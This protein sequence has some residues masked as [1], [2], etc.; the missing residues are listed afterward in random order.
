G[1][2]WGASTINCNLKRRSGILYNEAY[3]ALLVLNRVQMVKDPET[4]K[5]ISR[6]N[7]PEQWHVVEA[8]HLRIVSDELWNAVQTRKKLYGATRLHK[9]RRPKHMFSGLV[10]CVCCGATYTIKSQDQL[11][12]TAH[13]ER[14]TC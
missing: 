2:E 7:P 14:G 4:G 5:R 9:R 3:I 6:P 1:R 10:R 12:C 13:R 11:A 8:P